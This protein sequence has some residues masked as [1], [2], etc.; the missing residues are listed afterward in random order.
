MISNF[1]KLYNV[2]EKLIFLDSKIEALLLMKA[3]P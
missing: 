3:Q 2:K 1:S